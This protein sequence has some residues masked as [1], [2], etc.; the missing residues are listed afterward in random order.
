[1]SETFRF[2]SSSIRMPVS[3]STANSKPG[4]LRIADRVR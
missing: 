2:T 4:R 1:M 3:A